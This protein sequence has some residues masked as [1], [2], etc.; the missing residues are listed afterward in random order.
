MR[1]VTVAATAFLA[2]T[3]VSFAQAFDTTEALLEAF[4]APYLQGDIPDYEDGTF[5]SSRLQGLYEHDSEITPEGEMG[6]I[7][8]DPF[9]AGQDFDLTDFAIGTPIATNDAA[10][11]DVSFSNFETPVT[12]TYD[13]VWEDDSWKIDDV[14]STDA[15]NPYMLSEIFAA[16]E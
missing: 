4:Y 16:A 12:L 10:T 3:G 9:I 7:E 5:F 11:V 15:D 13:L 1:L 6:A 2:L 14:M 8:F